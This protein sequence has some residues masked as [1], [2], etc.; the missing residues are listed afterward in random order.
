M[1]T[2]ASSSGSTCSST[3][4]SP[5]RRR[6]ASRPRPALPARAERRSAAAA[7][8]SLRPMRDRVTTLYGYLALL[9][10]VLV[11]LQVFFAGLGIFGA[12]SF[13]THKSFGNILHGLTAVL[14]ILAT[15]GPRTGRDIGMAAGLVILVTVQIGLV[16]ARDDAPGLAALHPVLALAAMGLAVHMGIHAL[17]ARR[18]GP[19]P[20][21]RGRRRLSACRAAAPRS[22]TASGTPGGSSAAFRCEGTAGSRGARAGSPSRRSGRRGACARSSP[23]PSTGCGCHARSAGTGTTGWTTARR[24]GGAG[25]GGAW[26]AGGTA[27]APSH[28]GA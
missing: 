3:A 14:L 17:R 15:V 11:V 6:A 5:P 10:A 28:G 8:V 26:G 18:A 25:R 27:G 21:G 24:C 19:A 7:V 4:C 20:A 1:A 23:R 13:E 12:S 22:P 2:S 9:W 16:S